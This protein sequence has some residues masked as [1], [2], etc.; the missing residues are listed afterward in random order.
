MACPN[1]ALDETSPCFQMNTTF[2]RGGGIAVVSEVALCIT[3][4]HVV[5]G[6]NQG[7]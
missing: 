2:F 7:F 1:S 5:M 6:V 3:G 4:P